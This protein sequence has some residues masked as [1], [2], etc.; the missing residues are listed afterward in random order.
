MDTRR[1]NLEGLQRSWV[2][3]SAANIKRR[4]SRARTTERR[5]AEQL[6]EHRR[7]M[8]RMEMELAAAEAREAEERDGGAA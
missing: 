5:L 4:L 2:P 1:K 7:W 3:G 8:L 6:D